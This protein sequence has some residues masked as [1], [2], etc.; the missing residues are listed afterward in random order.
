MRIFT[1]ICE[2]YNKMAITD[3]EWNK[4]WQKIDPKMMN[5][6]WVVEFNSDRECYK[7]LTKLDNIHEQQWIA[8][9]FEKTY[10][11]EI[12]FC[13]NYFLENF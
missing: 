10:A 9:V 13:H 3:E 8:D 6:K 7:I 5:L 11:D 1:Y 12:V 2:N 4:H